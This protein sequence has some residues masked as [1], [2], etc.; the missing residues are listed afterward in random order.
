MGRISLPDQIGQLDH[1]AGTITLGPSR[2]TIGGQQYRT[3][4]NLSLAVAS[5]TANTLYMIYA[6]LNS[7][8]VTLVKST[9]VNSIGPAGSTSWKLVGAFYSQAVDT[10]GAFVN[11][12]GAPTTSDWIVDQ[13]FQFLGATSNPTTYS[14][15][16]RRWSRVGDYLYGHIGI[17]FT[18]TGIGSGAYQFTTPINFIPNSTALPVVNNAGTQLLLEGN[19]YAIDNSAGASDNTRRDLLPVW[20]IANGVIGLIARGLYG[21]VG[22]LAS[23]T[24]AWENADR[25]TFNYQMPIDGWSSTPLKDL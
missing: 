25:I 17:Q 15:I 3:T 18:G 2:I 11:I 10:F 13:D 5:A 20:V 7:G 16:Q 1:D 14:V 9:N 19:G 12:E 8:S 22:G 24:M 23:T 6:I 4:S 21:T